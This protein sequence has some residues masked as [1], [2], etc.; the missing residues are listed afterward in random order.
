MSWR[1]IQRRTVGLQG[2]EEGH[3]RPVLSARLESGPRSGPRRTD[4]PPTPPKGWPIGSYPTQPPRRKGRRLPCPISSSKQQ[5][6]IVGV[7]LMQVE[8]IAVARR[9]KVLGGGVLTAPGWVSS[10]A[11]SLGLLGDN[12]G[13]RWTL[14][15]GP[16]AGII[17]GFD[18]L[19]HTLCKWQG[20]Q[21]ISSPPCGWWPVA[22][23]SCAIPERRAARDM[24]SRLSIQTA[25]ARFPDAVRA[26]VRTISPQRVSQPAGR[27]LRSVTFLGV[28]TDRRTAFRSRRRPVASY[29]SLRCAAPPD[30]DP[31]TLAIDPVQA[32]ARRWCSR[33]DGR[34]T[35]G[36]GARWPSW[37]ATRRSTASRRRRADRSRRTAVATAPPD[38]R[39][40]ARWCFGRRARPG[41]GTRRDQAGDP[42]DVPGRHADAEQNEGRVEGAARGA[43]GSAAGGH[44][45][46][47]AST[48]P[49]SAA[50]QVRRRRAG[51]GTASGCGGSSRCRGTR[52]TATISSS[53]ADIPRSQWSS[54]VMLEVHAVDAGDHGRDGGDGA[55]MPGSRAHPCSAACRPRARAACARSD[56][57]LVVAG[58]LA[59]RMRLVVDHV[60]HAS[61]GP[62]GQQIL[63]SECSGPTRPTT[64]TPARRSSTTPRLSR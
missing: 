6:T 18:H 63:L 54:G 3:P 40:S 64:A 31:G 9:P 25:R 37:R 7:D 32:R 23:T 28:G 11:W 22:T 46:R 38:C 17:F 20:V 45:G 10:S 42:S 44:S 43:I 27:C 55:P 53:A 34:P 4:R 41:S 59:G 21:G 39:R 16:D 29:F 8:R 26:H 30:G 1:P 60:A 14:L 50:S 19:G 2:V 33:C 13:N 61:A 57:I 62:P 47:T 35:P 15:I 48:S 5:V 56:S 51:S 24:L 49:D 36:L 12:Q 58:D 52:R